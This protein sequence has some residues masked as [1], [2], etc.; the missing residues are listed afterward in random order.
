[1]AVLDLNLRPVGI[2]QVGRGERALHGMKR[3]ALEA[4]GAVSRLS[5]ST[6]FA[7]VAIAA[8]ATAFAAKSVAAY[9]THN[10]AL[11]EVSTL[12]DGSAGD[13]D[14]LDAAA[15]RFA[16]TFGGSATEQVNAFY[17]AI[18]AG[19]GDVAD[20]TQF[21]ETANTLALGGVTDITTAVD[22]LTTATNAYHISG[23]QA[24]EAAD[25]IFV[26]VKAGKTTV[27]ELSS[28]LG[29]L[30]PITSNVGI[31]FDQVVA[32]VAS[33]TTQGQSTAEAVTGLRAAIGAVLKPSSEAQ[34]I[35]KALGIE[36]T[37]TALATKGFAEFLADIVV[38]TGGSQEA[39]TSL[40]GSIESL[41]AVM[42]LAGDAGAVYTATMNEM[43]ISSGA[44][45]AAADKVADSLENRLSVQLAILSNAGLAVGQVLL[46]VI[47]PAM[48]VVTSS[49]AAFELVIQTLGVALIG[50]A[51][52]QIPAIV[53]GLVAMVV[54]LT[55]SITVTGL[56]TGATTL[57]RGA[58]IALGGPLG[59][60][61]GLTG[62]AA[63][64]FLI[65]RDNAG[66]AETATY[67]AADGT[68]ALNAALGV[69][70]TTAAPSAGKS[71]IDLANDNYKL[72]DSAVAAAR[73]EIAKQ[74]AIISAHPNAGT[75]GGPFAGSGYLPSEKL[76]ADLE[77]LAKAERDLER[78]T[79]DRK[80]TAN[81][82]TG[83]DFSPVTVGAPAVDTSGISAEIQKIL[84]GLGNIGGS[85]GG[86]ASKVDT[87]VSSFDVLMASL[88][89]GYA[90]SLKMAEGLKI[91][92]E[93]LDA[94][95]ISAEQAAS[96][97]E[98]LQ[99][100]I[101]EGFDLSQAQQGF[102][103]F[104]KSILTGAQSATEAL[105]DLAARA[106]D[107]LL[108]SALDRI[109]ESLGRINGIGGGSFLTTALGF[110]FSANGNVFNAGNV[111]PFANGTVVGSP[112]FFP[113]Q[114]GRTGLMGEAGPEAIMPLKRGPGG[115]LG[116]EGGGGQQKPSAINIL[117]DRGIFEEVMRS[118]G[119]ESI[120]VE[121]MLR[122]G[123]VRA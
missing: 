107:R 36:F 103:G 65:F 81:V 115:K 10:K 37:T 67:S 118:N 86:A 15:K 20:A 83:S 50:L 94:E 26:G 104:F 16:A 100:K 113:L 13:M 28:A 34:K 112:T 62:A 87:L 19:V 105:A 7:F 17:Q 14:K 38:K 106:A 91:I 122:S 84:D 108:T 23:L 31:G 18:S 48:E 110:L 90:R 4:E 120:M 12:L 66:E 43:A 52:T 89:P 88:D 99:K 85:A 33:L 49:G 80:N 45:Q 72:A 121:T 27:A 11:A 71:A 97:T 119:G 32:G 75:V 46:G 69:F 70:Y 53:A 96:A 79:R 41:P 111:V 77:R 82:V 2:E 63:A 56:L 42:A 68:K 40:F 21:M 109:F 114:D 61:Y 9:R 101:N 117:F 8:G 93:A 58:L 47:V 25:A 1:M 76:V 73:A 51:A 29:K 74:K 5:R 24:A 44:A 6:A 78:A 57:L 102:T 39:L 54:Q 95:A 3:G 55:A 123:F 92:Q 60:V 98:L 64:Y 30:L 116:V 22:L 35:A 59:L